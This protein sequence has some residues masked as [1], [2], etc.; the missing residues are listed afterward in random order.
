[1]AALASCKAKRA[2][3]TPCR[4]KCLHA[5]GAGFATL[6]SMSAVT[7]DTLKFVKTLH[8][9]GMPERQAEAIA[10]AVR[11][12]H[13]AA[14]LVTRKDLQIELASIK[15][16]LARIEARMDA[17]FE[18]FRQEMD[19]KFGQLRQEMDARFLQLEQRMTIKLG[20]MLVVAVGVASTLAKLL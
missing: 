20:T 15:A 17:R 7:F 19:A 5:I 9:S 14:D 4:E 18:Q 8:A 6:S 16:D 1:M 13:D 2:P 10:A 3:R 11:D 12:S